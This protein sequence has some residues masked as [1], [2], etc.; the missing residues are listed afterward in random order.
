[1]K[2]TKGNLTKLETILKELGFTTRYEKGNFHAGY[3]IVQHKKIVVINKFYELEGRVNCI[4][5][6]LGGIQ[7]EN[8]EILSKESLNI[9][10]NIKNRQLISEN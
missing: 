3:C 7:I 6:I 8:P 5:D 9:V 4:M 2:A 1:M 10:E